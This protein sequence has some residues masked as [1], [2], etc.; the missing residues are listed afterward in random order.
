MQ[1]DKN[2][3][4]PIMTNSESIYQ[5]GNN[6]YGKPATALNILRETIIGRD[7]FDF[8]FQQYAN[9]WKFKHPSPADLFRTMED[10]SGIDLDWFWRGWFYTTDHVDIAI[11]KVDWYRL[12]TND[13]EAQKKLAQQSRNDAPRRIGSIRNEEAIEKTQDEIDTS[14]RD[15]YTEYN[16]LDVSVLD[17]QKHQEY[18]NS[19]SEEERQFLNS[20][21]NYYE[22]TFQNKGG[23]VMPL[24]LKFT[25][26]DGSTQEKTIPAE[27]WRLR[28][29]EVS[30]IFVF[31]KILQ[32]VELDPYLETADTDRSNNYFPPR[33]QKSRFELY[34]MKMLEKE[35]AKENPMQRQQRAKELEGKSDGTN[36]K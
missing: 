13:P 35:R 17:R 31:D 18:L 25:F 9:R 28:H 21:T 19:L 26:E 32:E 33:P 6:A 1:G 4:T 27:I 36:E 2:N 22:L 8:A 34:R 12:D 11:D 30:K 5:F 20:G 14:L 24:I 7:L 23:L 3:M 29:H 10:A 16:P 15:F